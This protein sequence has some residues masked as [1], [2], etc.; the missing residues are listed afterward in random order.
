MKRFSLHRYG[1]MLHKQVAEDWKRQTAFTAV[2]TIII[3]MTF[4]LMNWLASIGADTLGS[5]EA[6][7]SARQTFAFVKFA[8]VVS[9]VCLAIGYNSAH[10]MPF[11]RS[12]RTEI[13][14]LVLPASVGEKYAVVLTQAL[15]LPLL[16]CAAAYLIA[17]LLQWAITGIFTT[18]DLVG[19]LG[20]PDMPAE[21][22]GLLSLVIWAVL[23]STLLYSAWFTFSAT[24]FRKH[25]FL[26]GILIL[27]G[28]QQVGGSV[29]F[30]AT[31]MYSRFEMALS[32][33]L[34]DMNDLQIIDSVNQIST[35]M[36]IAQIVIAV[37]L[38]VWS[39]FRMKRA[40]I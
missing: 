24:L 39:Y 27:W 25:P 11:R 1:L 12:R 18:A 5:P 15:V 23:V 17:D 19:L 13:A 40:Q 14:H 33:L 34:S 10:S 3:F 2:I 6:A 16:E 35:A 8:I 28:I 31:G 29:L 7:L 32:S 4:W 38:W 21:M 30:S 36:I 37:V 22:S 9:V 26:F 20:A